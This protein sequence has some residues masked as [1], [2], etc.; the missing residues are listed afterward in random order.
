MATATAMTAT[1]PASADDGSEHETL[2][3]RRGRRTGAHAIIAR[4]L[5]RSSAP[6]WAA[7]GCGDTRT[8]ARRSRTRCDSPA[9]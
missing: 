7:A 1:T 6:R 9:R 5:D 2:L 3:V 8:C 4:A